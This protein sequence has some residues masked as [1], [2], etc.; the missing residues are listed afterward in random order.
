MLKKKY[1]KVDKVKRP[2]HWGGW[3][4]NPTYIEFWKGRESRLHDRIVFTREDNLSTSK[5]GKKRLMSERNNS[6][7]WTIK[8]L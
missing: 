6:I 1:E 5:V 7:K 4:L 2:P 3:R 8:R